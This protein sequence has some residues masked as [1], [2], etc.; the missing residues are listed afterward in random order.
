MAEVGCQ[1]LDGRGRNSEVGCE[2]QPYLSHPI[3]HIQPP[4]SYLLHPTSHIL[5]PTSYLPQAWRAHLCKRR[6]LQELTVPTPT[7]SL[8]LAVAPTCQKDAC[9]KS[10]QC[11]STH[12][13]A[14]AELDDTQATDRPTERP[15]AWRG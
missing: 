8:L 11:Q 12:A 9:S 2:S 5:P 10:C 6:L 13:H 7:L 4:T 15:M 1:G 14:R 3:S